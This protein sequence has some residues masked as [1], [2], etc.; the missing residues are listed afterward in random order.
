[1]KY[2]LLLFL[3][4][5]TSCSKPPKNCSKFKTGTFEYKNYD[6]IVTRNDSIQIEINNN[7]KTKTVSSIKWL[8]NCQYILTYKETNNPL[9]KELIGSKIKVD[10]LSVSKNSY[11]YHAYDNDY[12]IKGK[13]IKIAE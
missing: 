13:M 10:I 11:I 12:E 8:S 4:T 9:A 3:L 6:S 2:L 7:K 1:M 5:A